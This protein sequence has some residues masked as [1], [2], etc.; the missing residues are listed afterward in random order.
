MANRIL[1]VDD[2]LGTRKT[3]PLILQRNGFAVTV[4]A[5]VSEALEHIRRQQFD[6]FLCDLN[7][8]I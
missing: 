5:T 2:E 6:I 7:I 4:A 1:F 3:L 8:W